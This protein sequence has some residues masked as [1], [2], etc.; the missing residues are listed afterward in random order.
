MNGFT[1]RYLDSTGLHLRTHE[2]SVSPISP[3]C[4]RIEVD[5]TPQSALFRISGRF[6]Q[7]TARRWYCRVSHELSAFRHVCRSAVLRL[8]KSGRRRLVLTPPLCHA[9]SACPEDQEREI[10]RSAKE[11]KRARWARGVHRVTHEWRPRGGGSSRRRKS[12]LRRILLYRSLPRRPVSFSHLIT[13][14]TASPRRN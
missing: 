11:C 12:G 9:C 6:T 10:R 1:A 2:S 8:I 4:D 5:L 14:L 7:V 13:Y 3:C